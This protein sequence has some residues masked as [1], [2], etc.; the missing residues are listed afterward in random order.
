MEDK[1]FCAGQLHGYRGWCVAAMADAG[2]EKLLAI[3]F[4]GEDRAAGLPVRVAV[5]V[6]ADL[7]AEALCLCRQTR[8][9]GA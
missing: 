8:L 4:D 3:G 5:V 6:Y 9:D 1:A 2:A 7:R